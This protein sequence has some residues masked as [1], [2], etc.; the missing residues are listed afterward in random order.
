MKN[1][2]RACC[3]SCCLLALV[4]APVAA[5][6]VGVRAG[7]SGD[8]SQF[9]VGVHTEMGPVARQL[10]FRPNLEVGVGSGVTT[11]TVNLEFAYHLN[12][13]RSQWHPY[14]GA[15]PALVISRDHGHSNTQGGF[16]ILLGVQHERGFFTELKVG[17]AD[18][19]SVK[20]G[21]GYE[22]KP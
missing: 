20:F 18:S 17:L 22:F 21:V 9:Y 12:V 16:N 13:R 14:I 7:V 1:L 4:S 6:G 8:P 15:G 19:P 5:Q 11:T 10:W 3:V 2:L